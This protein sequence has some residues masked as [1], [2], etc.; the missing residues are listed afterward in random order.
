MCISSHLTI[1]AELYHISVYAHHDI[2]ANVIQST[3]KNTVFIFIFSN[4]VTY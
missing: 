3:V 4:H 1:T 2:V